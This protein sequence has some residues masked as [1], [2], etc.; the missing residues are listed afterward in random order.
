MS[1][2]DFFALHTRSMDYTY[3]HDDYFDGINNIIKEKYPKP[4]QAIPIFTPLI[5]V[6]KFI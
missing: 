6:D 5:R 2:F 4:A 1:N 3:S